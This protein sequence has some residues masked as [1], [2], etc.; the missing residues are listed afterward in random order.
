MKTL[1]FI[2]LAL[3][4]CYTGAAQ[5]LFNKIFQADTMSM[6]SMAIEPASDSGYIVVGHYN[7]ISGNSNIYARK[8]DKYGNT[9]KIAILNG[10]TTYVNGVIWGKSLQTTTDGNYIVIGTKGSDI[11][12]NY[13]DN[14]LIKFNENLDVIWQK[15]YETPDT[16]EGNMQL[17]LTPDN[18][19]LL[20]GAAAA[21]NP[22][23]DQ[24][25][26]EK[27][28]AVK[29]DS[30]GNKQWTHTYTYTGQPIDVC[31][32]HDG[33][34]ILSGGSRIAGGNYDMTIIK[35]DSIGGVVWQKTF[36]TNNKDD[37]GCVAIP[38]PKKKYLVMGSI[39]DTEPTG[40]FKSYFAILDSMGNTIFEKI[41]PN[42]YYYS[43][44]AWPII[45]GNKVIVPMTVKNYDN[46]YNLT[47]FTIFSMEGDVLHEQLIDTGLP[48]GNDYLR[49][50]EA[51]PDGG[52][53]M[54]GFNYAYPQSSWIVKVDSLGNT[55]GIANCDNYVAP[56]GINAVSPNGHTL[57]LY[58]NPA[59]NQAIAYLPPALGASAGQVQVFSLTGKLLQSTPYNAKQQMV[60]F[61]VA[62]LP[63]GVYLVNVNG[64]GTTKLVVAH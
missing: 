59:S 46:I 37:G 25:A 6:L 44:A 30:I 49:D 31:Y 4:G 64:N 13:N 32:A 10:D 43:A 52:Y 33:G 48:T 24:W 38:F 28:Y 19:Y 35:I 39:A 21:H 17:I 45:Q 40:D 62:Q 9:Q 15:L 53:V 55:C 34:Y 26:Y 27:F 14:I 60:L 18:G 41:M 61:S 3:G 29:T 20:V 56:V 23:T 42:G 50:F 5:T 11:A 47:Y 57:L 2:I 51:S 36:G 1:V 16:T 12:P 58:P 8:V 22:I 7:G 54:A 63:A